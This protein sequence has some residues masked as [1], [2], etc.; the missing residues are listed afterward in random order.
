MFPLLYYFLSSFTAFLQTP[1]R[2]LSCCID[3][4]NDAQGQKLSVWCQFFSL[5]FSQFPQIQRMFLTMITRRKSSEL[6]PAG[7]MLEVPNVLMGAS[8]QSTLSAVT[9]PECKVAKKCNQE[10]DVAGDKD[11]GISVAGKEGIPPALK[12]AMMLAALSVD[13]VKLLGAEELND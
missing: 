11:W 2:P 1:V 9:Q 13:K 4:H 5:H 6:P 3:H 12:E 8:G 7:A 10:G